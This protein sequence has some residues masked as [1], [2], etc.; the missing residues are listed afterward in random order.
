MTIDGLVVFIETAMN[1]RK[2]KISICEAV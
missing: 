1:L 2:E